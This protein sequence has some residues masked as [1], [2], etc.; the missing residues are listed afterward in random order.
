[1]A[2]IIC[3]TKKLV[4]IEA[5]IFDKDG[6]LINSAN[7]LAE[8]AKM[9]ISL[10]E[11]QIPNIAEPLSMALGITEQKLRP[12]GL[13]AVGSRLEN[14]IAVAAY[15]T[16][17]GKSWF[18][19]VAIARQAFVQA[20]QYLQNSPE[21]S[22]LFPGTKEV[23]K[24]LYTAGCKLGILSADTTT[25]VEKF[26][27]EHQLS[28]YIK[29][30]KG[31]DYGITKP[32]P[33]LFLQACQALGVTPEKTIMIGDSPGDIHMAKKAGASATIGIDYNNQNNNYLD[34]ADL[35]IQKLTELDVSPQ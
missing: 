16:A 1:M 24:K 7:F 21:A 25:E 6:T 8:L 5:I 17:R 12:T 14:E 33:V 28:K 3:K 30:A 19:A 18:E 15:I 9:R 26:V 23:I 10:L 4:N 34:G 22:P 2:T 20:D 29:L 13:M 32:D 11:A 31:S 35:V 27:N